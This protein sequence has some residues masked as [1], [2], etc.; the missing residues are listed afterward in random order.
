MKAADVYKTR[1]MEIIDEGK[2]DGIQIA[3]Y[4]KKFED[5]NEIYELGIRISDGKDIIHIPTWKDESIEI[6]E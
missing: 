3:A 1:I 5:D 4:E 2:L 6:I